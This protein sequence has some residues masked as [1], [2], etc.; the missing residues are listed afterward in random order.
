MATLQVSE[1]SEITINQIDSG[2]NILSGKLPESIVRDVSEYLEKTN[3]NNADY[4]TAAN[5]SGDQSLLDIENPLMVELIAHLEKGCCE[6]HNSVASASSF[7]PEIFKNPHR[8][9]SMHTCWSVKMNPGDYNPIHIHTTDAYSGL[10]SIVYLKVPEHIR[11]DAGKSLA[12][13]NPQYHK[14]DGL[15]QFVWHGQNASTFDDYIPDSSRIVIPTVG[16][17]Y[18]FPKWL[19][20]LVYPYKG[21]GQRWS[22][23]ANFNMFTDKELTLLDTGFYDVRQVDNESA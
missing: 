1:E 7:T 2:I 20:H 17:F 19:A 8:T 14:L 12:D 9:V 23:Q 18:I 4:G 5:I 21:E 16:E 22:V 13:P 3:N 11:Q 10:S 6:F 15:L